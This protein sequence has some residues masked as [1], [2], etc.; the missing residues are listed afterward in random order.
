[1]RLGRSTMIL[2]G[3]ELAVLLLVILLIKVAG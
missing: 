2:N 1:M 3:L